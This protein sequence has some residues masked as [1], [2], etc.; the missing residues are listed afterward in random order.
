MAREAIE[1]RGREETTLLKEEFLS[2]AAHDLRTPLTVLL[3]QAD[4]SERRLQRDPNAAIDPAGVM[5]IARESRR[6]RDLVSDLLEAQGSSTSAP[7]RTRSPRTCGG[8]CSRRWSATATTAPSSRPTFRTSPSSS[9]WTGCGL[10]Q[11]LDNLSRERP[12]VRPR[13][14]RDRGARVGRDGEARISVSDH[15]IGIPDGERGAVFERFVRASNA[16]ARSDTG[17]GL[18]LYIC[19]RIIEGHG[20]RIWADETPGGGS[21]FHVSLPAQVLSNRWTTAHPATYPWRPPQ[22]MVRMGDIRVLVVDDE[23]DI[24]ATVAEMLEIEGYSVEEASNGADA[25]APSSCAPGAD[26][27]RHAHARARRLGFAAE[28]HRREVAIPIVVMTAAR[29][30]A[31]WAAEIAASGSLSKPFG[32]D[33]LIRTVGEVRGAPEATPLPPSAAAVSEEP[34]RSQHDRLRVDLRETLR[35]EARAT[36]ELGVLRTEARGHDLHRRR[37]G[38]LRVR[39]DQLRRRSPGRACR[40]R[41]SRE[42]A[43][44]GSRPCARAAC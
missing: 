25:L 39:L 38:K 26:P 4:C 2:A 43:G 1:L 31:R 30:A 23:P 40:W 35:G 19:R 6:L 21:T 34:R 20:G 5:R 10:E 24:R 14:S 27:A 18:G 42:G 37:L 17:L 11:V 16:Q 28:L 29:D 9:G 8:S 22:E 7:A 41:A 3:G 15:G 33:D 12:Q 32:F 13:R 36:Q 44:G